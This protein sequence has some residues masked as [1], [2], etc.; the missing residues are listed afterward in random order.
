MD[1]VPAASEFKTELSGDDSAAAV[2]WITG[3]ADLHGH[4][5][6]IAIGFARMVGDAGREVKSRQR[7]IRG[8]ECA[9]PICESLN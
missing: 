3:D 6:D 9:S 8:G 1:I 7:Q 5:R 4:S 2:G